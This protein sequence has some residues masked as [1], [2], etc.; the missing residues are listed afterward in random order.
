MQVGPAWN[1][2]LVVQHLHKDR[3]AEKMDDTGLKSSDKAWIQGFQL[4][5]NEVVQEIGGEE[6]AK[7]LYAE[8]AK[9]WNE[10]G[11]PEEVKRK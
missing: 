7:E 8:T 5:V 10:A 2:R 3:I 11:L 4:A 1:Y 9:L 6:K